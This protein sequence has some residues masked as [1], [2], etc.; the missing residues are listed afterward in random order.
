[1]YG[2]IV[3]GLLSMNFFVLLFLKVFVMKQHASMVARA[4]TTPKEIKVVSV[5]ST[6]TLSG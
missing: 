6:A 3:V 2:V 4:S 5:F 1:M